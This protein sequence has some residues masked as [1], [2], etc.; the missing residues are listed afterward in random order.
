MIICFLLPYNT[1]PPTKIH[2]DMDFISSSNDRVVL[3]GS[4][5]KVKNTPTFW[6]DNP[7]P[8]HR[9]TP[10]KTSNHKELIPLIELD[11]L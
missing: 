11:F 6:I 5:Y 9:H 10:E 7:Y 8:E 4:I 3:N 1:N 2:V